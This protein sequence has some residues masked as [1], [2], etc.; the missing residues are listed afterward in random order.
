MR[1]MQPPCWNT[2]AGCRSWRGYC[3]DR[4]WG[5]RNFCVRAG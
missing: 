1:S 4:R 5:C 3:P 2:C